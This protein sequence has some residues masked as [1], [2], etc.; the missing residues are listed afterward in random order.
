[1]LV[2]YAVIFVVGIALGA[3]WSRLPIRHQRSQP[4]KFPDRLDDIDEMILWGEVNDDPFYRG[5]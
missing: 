2:L 4:Q 5:Y 3:M 1:M